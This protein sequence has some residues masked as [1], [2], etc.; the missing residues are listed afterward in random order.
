MAT[1][2]VTCGRA[3]LTFFAG[4]SDRFSPMASKF[5][6]GQD[7]E[8]D[9][10]VR[11]RVNYTVE[12]LFTR[13]VA[14]SLTDVTTATFRI[15]GVDQSLSVSI[16]A[17]MTGVFR[18]DT[19]SI[20]TAPGDLNATRWVPGATGGTIS[21]SLVSY[22]YT[23]ASTQRIF[24]VAHGDAPNVLW[25]SGVTE[26]AIISGEMDNLSPE[27]TTQY[28]MRALNGVGTTFTNM[29]VHV[30]TNSIPNASTLTIRRN[31]ADGA[32]TVTIPASTSG[33]FEDTANSETFGHG[34][35]ANYQ[36]VTGAGGGTL[37]TS[38]M[39][40][41]SDGPTRIAAAGGVDASSAG[42]LVFVTYEGTSA[43]STTL[44]ELRTQQPARSSFQAR[45]FFCR[46]TSNSLDGV[47]RSF[48]RVNSADSALGVV[49]PAGLTGVFENADDVVDVSALDQVNYTKDVPAA[50]AGTITPRYISSLY[51]E[52]PTPVAEPQEPVPG[53]TSWGIGRR[54]EML[55]Y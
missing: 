28:T 55:P 6:S 17:G 25:A 16:P 2:L 39:Q 15:S 11:I 3:G 53:H 43:G 51:I 27:S 46:V 13:I 42:N 8:A 12:R 29:R 10:E 44:P 50:S 47:Y 45:N 31:E 26:F 14:N 1:W 18:D 32:L 34:D 48:L 5:S 54:V 19:S 30:V 40:V 33:D 49:V 36:L 21:L 24:L 41:L 52:A 22:L 4:Q 20:A 7:T 37:Q 35:R 9:A 38:I 23:D